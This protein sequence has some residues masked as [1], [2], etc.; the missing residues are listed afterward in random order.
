MKKLTTSVLAVVLTSS[1]ALVNAQ[2][3]TARTDIEG[4]V[5]TALGIK[6]ASKSLGYATQSIKADDVTK[7]PTANF[8]SNLSGKVAGLNV[9]S[10]GNIGGSV[11]ITLRGYRSMTGNNSVLF[12]VDGAPMINS[13]TSINTSRLAV[14]TGNT[15]SDI[16]PED[17]AEINVLKGAAAT[18]LYGSRASNGAIIITTKKGKRSNKLD[19]DFSSSISFTEINK[20]TF[21]KYQDKYGQ[22]Y[23]RGYGYAPNDFFDAYQGQPLAPLYEDASYGAAYDPNLLVWQYTAFIPGSKDFGKATPWVKATHDPSYLFEKA[24]SFNNS[25]SVSKANDVSSFRLSYQNVQGNDILPNSRLDKNSVTGNASYKIADNLTANLYATYVV[26]ETVGK[27][28]TGYH[29]MMGNFRQWWATNVDMYDQRDLYFMNKANNSW[30]M[31]SPSNTAPLYW[32]NPYFR[33]Y[34]NYISDERQRFAGNFS[35]SYDV[36]SKINLLGRVSHD[37]FNYMIDER[38]AVG[39]LPDTMSIGPATGN[40][41]SGYAVTN[42]RRNEENFDFIGTYKDNFSENITFTGLLGTNINIQKLY[43]NS[44]GTQGGLFIPGV[45]AI[46]NSAAAMNAPLITDNQKRIYGL[47]AQASLGFYDTYFVEGSIRRDVSTALPLHN[48]VYWYPSISG[49]VVISNWSFLKDS[50]LNFGKIRASYAQV[51]SDTGANQLLNTYGVTTAFGSPTYVYNT[52]AKNPDLKPEMTKSLEAGI[53]LQF[54]KNRIGIDAGW[55]RNDTSD[56]ILALPVTSASGTPF[57]FQNVGNMRSHGFEVAL[58]LVPIKTTDF[59]WGLDVNWSNPRSK[60]T[61]LSSGVKN[62]TLG[63]FQGGVTINASL[64]DDYGTIKGSDFTYDA[65]GNKIIAANGKYALSNT[66][67]KIGNMQADWIGSV[68]NRISY[69]EF[70]LSFQIDVKQGGQLFSLDQY[71]GQATGLYPETVFLNDLGN[72]VRNSLAD[73]GGLIL[74]GVLANGTPNNIRLDAE[75]FG[76]MGYNV[77][78]ASQFVYDASYVKLREVA[79]TYTMPKKFLAS[80][81]VQGASFSLIGNNLW[82]IKKHVPYAD[83]E[84]GLSAGNV[85]GY[86]TSVLPTTRTISFNVRLNF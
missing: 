63:S 78:P 81:F 39:S 42:Q 82:I 24:F 32:D 56:Q 68:T 22:G 31:Q 33:L 66:D 48:N 37:G 76:A 4:V 34:E 74:P 80:T 70:A 85:Q 23:G 2:K 60:V 57:K 30:N 61:E 75:S 79:L 6:R 84:S 18:A 51:G 52:T 3:D 28:P 54:F 69:K 15:I 86:Q 40:Q 20:D 83:P 5:V 12:V 59:T 38:R 73:G 9:K 71:Y 72:P 8:S 67:A 77:Y 19:L 26:Q 41:P 13:Y 11:D 58:N 62:I 25:V 55:F 21:V 36:T 50:A 65:N 29:G 35:L 16:N 7:T 43:S 45:Y 64:D 49:S 47:F 27:N 46:S 53:N 14:D 44:Q 1:F 10:S 17:I